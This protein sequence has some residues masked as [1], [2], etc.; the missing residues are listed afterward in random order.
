MVIDSS[1]RDK[2]L[3]PLL[4][5]A[6]IYMSLRDALYKL[7]LGGDEEV[8]QA[9]E[10][11]QK[12]TVARSQKLR[13][14]AGHVSAS[15]FAMRKAYFTEGDERAL[16]ETKVKDKAM[17]PMGQ[18]DAMKGQLVGQ[19]VYMGIWYAVQSSLQGF[20]LL[21]LPFSLTERFK[22]ITQAGIAIPSLDTSYVSSGSLFMIALFGLPKIVALFQ[23]AGDSKF[24]FFLIMPGR[25]CEQLA[26]NL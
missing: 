3:I 16:N 25:I 11:K 8:V 13:T 15:A 2:V 9:E 4:L 14:N 10:V 19:V 21:K 18:M 5:L 17:N 23:N 24:S 6:F 12:L 22:Q 7:V 20:L 26:V 1:I